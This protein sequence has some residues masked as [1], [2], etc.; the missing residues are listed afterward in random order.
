MHIALLR[1]PPK[2]FV[3]ILKMVDKGVITKATAKKLMR[4][5][6]TGTTDEL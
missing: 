5:Y 4:A 1:L 2:W 3:M 6:F